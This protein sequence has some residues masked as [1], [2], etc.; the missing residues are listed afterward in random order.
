M[1]EVS[2][3]GVILEIVGFIFLIGYFTRI[4]DASW[5][6]HKHKKDSSNSSFI[7]SF[8]FALRSPSAKRY[9]E[10][11]PFNSQINLAGI[12]LIVMGLSFQLSFIMEL[13][14]QFIS[15]FS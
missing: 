1:M 2:D 14:Y 5:F 7:R 8:K 9:D 6:A 11:F 3:A 10:Y 12:L 15:L 13:Y 4:R